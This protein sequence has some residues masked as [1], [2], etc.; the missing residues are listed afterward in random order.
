[1]NRLCRDCG[2]V[3]NNSDPKSPRIVRCASCAQFHAVVT[4]RKAARAVEVARDQ[5]ARR[6][7]RAAAQRKTISCRQAHAAYTQRE[8][9]FKYGTGP[10][11]ATILMWSDEMEQHHYLCLFGTFERCCGCG[12]VDCFPAMGVAS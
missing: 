3:V 4:E 1:M 9:E 2:A 12:H 8:R 6:A 10:D 5:A 7:E 11:P